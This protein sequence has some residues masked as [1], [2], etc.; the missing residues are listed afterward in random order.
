LPPDFLA[1]HTVY[2]ASFDYLAAPGRSIQGVIRGRE[3]RK[4]V[5]GAQVYAHGTTH[6]GRTDKDG[7]YELLGCAKSE[8]YNVEVTPP[9]GSRYFSARVQLP[10]TPG[11]GALPGDIDLVQGIP[12]RGRLTDK[13]TGRPIA[14]ALVEYHALFPNGA[15]GQLGGLPGRSLAEATTAA[16][17]T[18][19]LAVL[20]GPGVLAFLARRAR[21]AYQE[22]VVNRKELADLFGDQQDHGNER[23]LRLSA[24]PNIMSAGL[25]VFNYHAVALIK[26]AEDAKT[27]RQNATLQPSQ[28]PNGNP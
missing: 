12:C 22:A 4:P 10:D 7:R 15:I 19:S 11:L 28:A 3:T 1:S 2:G 5:V 6:S 17:G 25:L 27:F 24:G 13:A 26:P 8:Q 14:G 23:V 21:N 18:F 20:P 9:N 16:D